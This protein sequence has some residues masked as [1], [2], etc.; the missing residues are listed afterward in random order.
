LQFQK[1]LRLQEARRLMQAAAA[2]VLIEIVR[3]M[4]RRMNSP[5]RQKSAQGRPSWL[6]SWLQHFLAARHYIALFFSNI[7]D[8]YQCVFFSF[9]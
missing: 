6:L 9:M 5:G 7:F 1:Q 4:A 8:L 3:Q 2:L